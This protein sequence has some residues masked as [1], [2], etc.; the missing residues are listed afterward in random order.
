MKTIA[1]ITGDII[2]GRATGDI[3]GVEIPAALVGEP[4]D[5]LRFDGSG[6]IALDNALRDYWIDALGLKHIVTGQGWQKLKCRVGD[7]LIRD[8]AV[9]RVKTATDQLDEHRARARAAV[10]K[11]ADRI[12]AQITGQYPAAEVASWPTQEAE[13]RAVVAGGNASAA[14][15]IAALAVAA[16]QTLSAYAAR[17]LEKSAEYRQVVAAVKALRDATDTALDAATT[18]VQIDAALTAS[19]ASAAQIA[20]SLT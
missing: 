7:E 10:I 3:V 4:D 18:E 19:Q 6:V 2:T 1:Q 20:A 8:G 9:W 13:A 14:P 15:L 12:T 5:R 11:I 17:V 16:G